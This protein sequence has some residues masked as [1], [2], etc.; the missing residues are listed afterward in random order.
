MAKKLAEGWKEGPMPPNT[1]GWGG[2][3][4]KGE[5][6]YN[7]FFFADFQGDHVTI[8]PGGDVVQADAIAAYNNCL[9]LPRGMQGA[10]TPTTPEEFRRFALALI[11][12]ALGYGLFVR[13]ESRRLLSALR[14]YLP[15]APEAELLKLIAAMPS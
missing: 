1:W 12:N 5:E 3:V 13:G 15:T 9:T 11:D 6:D 4:R 14:T 2:I 7:G 8:F 10:S